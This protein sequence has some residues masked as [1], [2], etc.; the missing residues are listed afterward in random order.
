MHLDRFCKL[1]NNSRDANRRIES[2]GEQALSFAEHLRS[3]AAFEPL[4]TDI[5]A[6][7]IG[8]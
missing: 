7:I 5:V 8:W 1:Q 2:L 6:R 3:S 4:N